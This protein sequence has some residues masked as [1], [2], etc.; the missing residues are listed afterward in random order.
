MKDEDIIRLILKGNS[1]LYAELID[2]YSGKVY[3][4]AYSYTQNQEEARDLVQEIL[5][6]A[7]NS[8][9][10]FKAEAK[11]STWLYR[12]AVNSCID[13]SRKRKSKVIMTALSFE[14]TNIFDN[15]TSDT[16]GPEEIVLQ[17]EHK[18]AVRNAVS[19]LPEIYKTV[20]ILYYF[21][22]LQVQEICNILDSPRKTIETRLYRAK[23]VLK[24]MLTQE[25]SG[26]E[27]YEL[28]NI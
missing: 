27:L 7:Y 12:I 9:Q 17:Q 21:E 23:K 1:D 11:F 15:I 14:D 22:E 6:K 13:W 5:I 25:L 4:T 26:G 8:L 2:R 16:E 19:S 24:S 28:Q 18:E 10:G 3:S 20:L